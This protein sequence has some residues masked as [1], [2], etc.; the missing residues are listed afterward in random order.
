MCDLLI[1]FSRQLSSNPAVASLKYEPDRGLQHLLNNF[2]QTYVFIDDEGGED[3]EVDAA[4]CS[5]MPLR[6]C[7]ARR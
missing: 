3:G 1:I 7:D 4:I 6:V 2:I 5:V